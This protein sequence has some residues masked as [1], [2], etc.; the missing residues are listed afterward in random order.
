M[1]TRLITAHT[2]ELTTEELGAIRTLLDV[3]F[4]GAFDDDDW[5]HSLGGTHV[6]VLEGDDVIAHGSLVMRRLLHGG[7]S[8]RAGYVEAVAVRPDRRRAGHASRVMAGLEE[9]GSAYDL[10]AL[11]AS[12]DGVALYESRGWQLWR[13]PTSV[14][15]PAGIRPTPDDDGSV[16]V[17]AGEIALD[18]DGELTADWRPGDVW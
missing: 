6:L 10:L 18:V 5:E 4:A 16:Y 15:T 11:S 12:D 2:G 14:L 9:L 1:V 3:A 13:G 17:L 7:R 8:L